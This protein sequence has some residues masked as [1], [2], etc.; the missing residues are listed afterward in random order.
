MKIALKA[1]GAMLDMVPG[2]IWALV[3]AG[4]LATNAASLSQNTKLQLAVKHEKALV[5]DQKTKTAELQSEFDT[6]KRKQAE[7]RADDEAAARKRERDLQ[8]AADNMRSQ[9]DAEIKR[10]RADVRDLR[11][12]LHTLPARPALS[13]A[14]GAGAAA[15]SDQAAGQCGAAILYREDGELLVD[16]AGRAEEIRIEYLNLF[17][18]YQRARE[19]LSN[20]K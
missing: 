17:D 13:G 20:T 4:L 15:S 18:L 6:Y 8:A 14:G 16:E 9:K 19:A 3:C 7:Q 5:A 1:I 10:L 2:W 11:Y 12:G